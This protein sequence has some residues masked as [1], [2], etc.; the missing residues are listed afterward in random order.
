MIRFLARQKFRFD[1]GQGFLSVVN[2]TFVVIAA[3]DKLA[4]L[5]AVPTK[6]LLLILV[7]SAVV[8]VWGLG[9]LLDHM[10][11]QHSYQDELNRRN[12]MLKRACGEQ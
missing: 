7:P 4:T 11:F 1:L 3:S 2:F 5:F 12:A 8:S 10:Q 6:V 9:F